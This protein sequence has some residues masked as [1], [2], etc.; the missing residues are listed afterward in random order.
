M[1]INMP[2]CCPN[3]P[4]HGK[5]FYKIHTEKLKSLGVPD[6]LLGFLKHFKDLTMNEKLPLLGKY[7]LNKLTNCM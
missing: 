1:K 7:E 2:D 5:P 6:D 3:E 4:L